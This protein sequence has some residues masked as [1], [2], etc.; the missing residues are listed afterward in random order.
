MVTFFSSSF[1]LLLLLSLFLYSFFSILINKIDTRNNVPLIIGDN[2]ASKIELSK[3]GDE[4]H[5]KGDLTVD[6]DVDILGGMTISGNIN[7]R[8]IIIDG[9]NID[10]H[11]SNTNNPHNVTKTKI[12]LSN[13]TNDLQI[14]MNQKGSINGIASLNNNGKVNINQLHKYD[15]YNFV[16]NTNSADYT[17]MFQFIYL[18]TDNTYPISSFKIISY[19]S[20]GAVNY[21]IRIKDYTN[22]KT[23]AEVSGTNTTQSIITINTLSNVPSNESII[24]IQAKIVGIGTCYLLGGMANY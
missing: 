22:N 4:T 13:V 11:L 5:I 9:N 14:P 15:Q 17:R 21:S 10:D 23:L 24:E 12:G 8:N 18:G 16:S 3:P 19:M 6:E 7:G 1:L 2:N 20:M